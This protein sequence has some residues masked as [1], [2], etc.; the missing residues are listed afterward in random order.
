MVWYGKR[1]GSLVRLTRRIGGSVGFVARWV[2]G[3]VV[4][5]WLL[6]AGLFR[7]SLARWFVGSVVRLARRL[8]GSFG[9]KARLVRWLGGSWLDGSFGS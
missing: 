9:S 1:Y 6:G 7:C 3:S 4:L 5:F 8:G 2:R